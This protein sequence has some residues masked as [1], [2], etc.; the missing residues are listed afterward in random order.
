[1]REVDKQRIERGRMEEVDKQ[2][3]EREGEWGR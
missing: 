1:M 3:I 2:R